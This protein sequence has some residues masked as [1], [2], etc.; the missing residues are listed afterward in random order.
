M[1]V[2]EVEGGKKK[3]DVRLSVYLLLIQLLEKIWKN[4]LYNAH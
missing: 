3:R 4:C 2:T 1:L